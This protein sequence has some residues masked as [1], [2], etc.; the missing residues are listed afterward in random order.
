MPFVYRIKYFLI[1]CYVTCFQIKPDGKTTNGQNGIFSKYAGLGKSFI[2]PYKS[3]LIP[4]PKNIGGN[5]LLIF[6]IL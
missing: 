2:L 4:Q 6:A 5:N 3:M 1:H